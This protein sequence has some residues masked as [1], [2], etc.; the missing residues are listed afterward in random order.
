MPGRAG[1]KSLDGDASLIAGQRVSSD[2]LLQISEGK[3]D[4]VHP[5]GPSNTLSIAAAT[6]DLLLC[7]ERLTFR[8][9]TVVHIVAET[10]LHAVAEAII[11]LDARAGIF[12]TEG[13]S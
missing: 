9:E 1:G 3:H 13:R 8:L 7:P 6:R 2:S 10:P 5:D 4:P 11:D 12:A